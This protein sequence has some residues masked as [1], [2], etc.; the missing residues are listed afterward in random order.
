MDDEVI[1][2]IEA[3]EY[4]PDIDETQLG[5]DSLKEEC[6]PYVHAKKWDTVVKVLNY[7]GWLRDG[8][9]CALAESA[10]DRFDVYPV[11]P[12]IKDFLKNGD[13]E[14]EA[15]SVIAFHYFNKKKW[16]EIKKLL[17]HKNETI[18]AETAGVLAS[19]IQDKQNITP[20]ISSL[21]EALNDSNVSVKENSASALAP[22][23]ICKR[24]WSKIEE[25]LRNP[26]TAV[27]AFQSLNLAIENGEDITPL[28]QI[29]ERILNSDRR[30]R[31]FRSNATWVL[32]SHYICREE[33]SKVEELLEHEDMESIGSYAIRVL[34]IA[35]RDGQY[36]TPM[37]PALMN[38]LMNALS[39]G[40]GDVR[41]LAEEALRRIAKK[42]DI[43]SVA[44][45]IGNALTDE[46]RYIV[47]RVFEIFI[48][49]WD[50]IDKLN[51]AQKTLETFFMEWR[52]KHPQESSRKKVNLMLKIADFYKLISYRKAELS[53]NEG[54]FL[55]GETIK[56]PKG[57]GGRY[58]QLRRCRHG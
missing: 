20:L 17:K 46:D 29:L 23:Y 26:D 37:V 9:L 18:R 14:K 57:K 5:V 30:T 10:R 11:I 24:E 12:V 47:R 40:D 50:S 7:K 6:K 22:H 44:S 15:V 3:D 35:A 31:N 16:G 27:S 33:W 42:Q 54:E 25:L 52:K 58:Q 45:A 4:D 39:N 43:V 51:K 38:A 28:T 55:I 56:P 53:R 13:V 49:E 36:V 19:A 21:E 34:G 2:R 41:W 48:S 32:A 1:G 8:M